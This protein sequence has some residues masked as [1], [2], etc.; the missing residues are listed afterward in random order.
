MLCVIPDIRRPL[1][2]CNR[3]KKNK[4]IL[5]RERYDFDDWQT[6][7]GSTQPTTQKGLQEVLQI[8]SALLDCHYIGF[9]Q[10]INAGV[11][12]LRSGTMVGRVSGY[13]LTLSSIN[14]LLKLLKI[15]KNVIRFRTIYD[16]RVNENSCQ[17]QCSLIG[18]SLKEQSF[19]WRNAKIIELLR[20]KPQM[21]YCENK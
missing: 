12:A 13:L 14:L 21:I 1:L 9:S 17:S 20:A 18:L 6:A 10:H 16:I 7:I 4:N 2:L 3:N 5:M 8:S 11:R 15:K 19:R